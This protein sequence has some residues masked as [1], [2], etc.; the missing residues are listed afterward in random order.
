MSIQFVAMPTADVR[1]YQ[2]GAPDAYGNPPERHISDGNGVPCRHCLSPVG[3]G[4]PYLTLAY[5][6]FSIIN[7]YSETG[8]V[9]LCAEPCDRAAESD[10]LPA[11]LYGAAYIVRGYDAKDRIIYGTGKVM[12]PAAI[13]SHAASL[14]HNRDVAYVHVRSSENNC[15]SC[16]IE[17]GQIDSA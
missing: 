6:P 4:K 11:S 10:R 1:T 3:A 2:D 7:P 15:F 9:F 5:R 16:R 12:R 13:A 17:R 14:L 8:P